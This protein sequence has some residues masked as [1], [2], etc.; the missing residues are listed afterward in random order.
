LTKNAVP[1]AFYDS[2]H[3]FDVP[4]RDEDTEVEAAILEK[5]SEWVNLA[6]ELATVIMWLYGGAGVGK[7]II[8]RAM[9]E[10]LESRQQL[11]A[12]FFFSRSDGSR[13]HIKSVIATLAYNIIL[14]VPES[15]PLITATIERDPHIF[16][17]PFKRQFKKLIL[18][19]LQQLSQQGVTYPIV[20]IIDGLDECINHDERTVLL[21]A[22]SVATTQYSAPLKFLITSRPEVQISGIFNTSPVN[23]VSTRHSL[24]NE[25][26]SSCFRFAKSGRLLHP[27]TITCLFFF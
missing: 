18:E 9:A 13:N 6:I 2:G 25:A 12:T 21:R 27:V 14:S 20:I 15:R 11:L 16:Q 23:E 17:R 4:Q 24:N 5:I 10:L 8:S 3:E 19:P 7:S 22:I 26:E 1:G